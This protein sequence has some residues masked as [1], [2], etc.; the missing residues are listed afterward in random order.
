MAKNKD[1]KV[2]YCKTPVHTRYPKGTSGNS[3]GRPKGRKNMGTMVNDVLSRRVT[4]TENGKSRNVS[5]MEAFVHQLAAKAL[6]GSTRD[7]IALFKLIKEHT[8]HLMEV[9]EPPEEIV[10]RFVRPEE[11]TPDDCKRQ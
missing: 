3:K 6:N 4:I 2:G 8:P 9:P 11:T 10:V 5:F 1:Y 7:Q